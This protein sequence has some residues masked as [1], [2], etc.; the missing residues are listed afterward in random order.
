MSTR[1]QVS[2]SEETHGDLRV[3]EF[4]TKETQG[5]LVARALRALLTAE[6]DLARKVEQAKK[7]AA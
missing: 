7:A 6:P 4:V 3:L 1:R 5:V 2:V